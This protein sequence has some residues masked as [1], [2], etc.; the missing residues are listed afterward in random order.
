[1]AS[2]QDLRKR[3]KT[4]KNTQQITKA[5]K[6]VASARLAK[7]QQKALGTEPYAQSLR[8]MLDNLLINTE[9]FKDPLIEQR[10]IKRTCYLVVGAD[11]GLAGAFNSNIFKKCLA[12][13]K[14][15][16][17]DEFCFVTCGRKPTEMLRHHG[18]TPV[19]SF[20]GHSDKPS[21]DLAILLANK[22]RELFLA[23]TVDRV[24]LIYTH[25]VNSLTYEIKTS[26]LLPI[27]LET[28]KSKVHSAEEF[29]FVPDKNA[30][31]SQLLPKATNFE[32]Y[33]AMLQSAASE[34]GSR[35]TAMTT[36]SDNAGGLIETL[37]LQYN[38]LRQ[39]QITN[40]ISEIIG[41]ANALQ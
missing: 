7:A 41:G 21:Y 38:R 3:I 10:E 34:L 23:G 31:L 2:S 4:V 35:M 5:M 14:D 11:K 25:F 9:G 36:A 26:Q 17:K 15:K 13:V 22:A 6:M 20:V 27:A 19:A 16:Q 29:I 33:G 30:V 1:M 40:E 37:N 28:D 32:I 8:A 18:I 24:V 12:L 39:A